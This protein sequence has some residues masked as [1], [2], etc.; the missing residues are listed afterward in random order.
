MYMPVILIAPRTCEACGHC[1]PRN[2]RLIIGRATPLRGSDL[3]AAVYVSM[4]I[5]GE[6]L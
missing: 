1:A 3:W 4:G 6:K 2:A 5:E